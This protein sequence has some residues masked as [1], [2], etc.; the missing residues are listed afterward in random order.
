M[1]KI[2]C[3]YTFLG[4]FI[5]KPTWDFIKPFFKAYFKIKIFGDIPKEKSIIVA[6]NHRSYLDPPVLNSIFKEPLVF[7]AKKELFEGKMGFLFNHMLALP[8]ERGSGNTQTLQKAI[9]CL[10]NGF[11]VG[12][13]PEGQRADPG[14]FLKP[15]I[16]VGVLAINSKRPVLPVYIENTDINMPKS[17]KIPKSILPINVYLGDL[18]YFDNY[19][20]CIEDYR[21]V[22]NKIMESIIYLSNQSKT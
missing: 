14:K 8:V 10:K 9:E 21:E 17:A 13:F 20:D 2:G 12:I 16:G 18:L 5:I 11:S 22:S 1:D 15:K 4:K 3:K 7:L 6:A 19:K